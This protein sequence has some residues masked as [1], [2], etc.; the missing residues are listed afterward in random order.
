MTTPTNPYDPHPIPVPPETPARIGSVS[1]V[2]RGYPV[3]PVVPPPVV[4][5]ATGAWTSRA[6]VMAYADTLSASIPR[7]VIPPKPLPPDLLNPLGSP[8]LCIATVIEVTLQRKNGV[9]IAENKYQIPP[10]AK[11]KTW[12][13]V[14]LLYR[15]GYMYRE[16]VRPFNP[17]LSYIAPGD[18]AKAGFVP[19]NVCGKRSYLRGWPFPFALGSAGDQSGQQEHAGDDWYSFNKHGFYVEAQIVAKVG[20]KVLAGLR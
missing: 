4:P 18:L 19:T 7:Y 8:W 11:G 2:G 6:Q 5:P 16:T 12:Y 10:A 1:R 9:L 15:P 17:P 3:P 14:G 20:A 13:D